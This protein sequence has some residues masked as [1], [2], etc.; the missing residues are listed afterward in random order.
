MPAGAAIDG[1]FLDPV[2]GS[3]GWAIACGWGLDAGASLAAELPFGLRG[4]ERWSLILPVR[5]A[6]DASISNS[7]ISKPSSVAS[8][9]TLTTHLR[10]GRDVGSRAAAF[11]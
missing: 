6:E 2:V 7:A 10:Q 1:T 5:A 9:G 4:P 3:A 11:S 8:S